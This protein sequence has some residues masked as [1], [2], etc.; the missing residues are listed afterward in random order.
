MRAIEPDVIDAETRE[1]YVQQ[2]QAR[3]RQ[4]WELISEHRIF[5]ENGAKWYSATI[6][7]DHGKN[8]EL[9]LLRQASKLHTSQIEWINRWILQQESG[10]AGSDTRLLNPMPTEF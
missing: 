9:E 10:L 6:I 1:D 2:L 8:I 5:G 3:L 4:G 7:Y